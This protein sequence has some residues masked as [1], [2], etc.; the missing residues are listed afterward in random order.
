MYPA[1]NAA[2]HRARRCFP[3]SHD[4]DMAR[5]DAM[6]ELL[7]FSPGGEIEA[8]ASHRESLASSVPD[9]CPIPGNVRGIC[10]VFLA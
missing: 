10:P 4:Q 3:L 6:A 8:I 1:N 2:G 5:S 7:G 9:Q